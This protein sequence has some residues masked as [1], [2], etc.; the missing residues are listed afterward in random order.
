MTEEITAHDGRLRRCPMLGHDVPF[1]Y[2]RTPGHELPCPKIGDC[3]W[4]TFDVE[5]F[6]RRH[7]SQ[8]DIARMLAA[9]QDKAATIVELIEKAR[10]ASQ[11]N[12]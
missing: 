6:I 10:K 5:T 11:S 4:E 1:S 9:R 3:W 2:C 8:Q 12:P 7:F